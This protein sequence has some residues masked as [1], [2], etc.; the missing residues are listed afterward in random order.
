VTPTRASRPLA[1]QKSQETPTR[2]AAAPAARRVLAQAAW[3]TRVTLRNGEQLLLTLVLP[4]LALVAMSRTSLIGLDVPAEHLRVD[5]IAP[6]VLAMAVMSSAFTGQAIATAFDRRYGVLR[7]LGTTPLGRSGLLLGRVLAVLAVEIVQFAV[8]GGVAAWLG[9]RPSLGSLLLAVPLLVLGTA[10]FA[11]LGLLMAGTMRA[12]AVLAGANLVW[13]L[14]LL[15]GGVLLPTAKLPGAL[16]DV[17]ALLPSGALA[18][19]LRS[20]FLDGALPPSS[21]PVLAGWTAV[22]VAA[23][24]RWFKWQ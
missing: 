22:A 8:L 13:V 19:G 9:W 6:G 20:V 15:G 24:I 1:V 11:A 21:L 17:A 10:A 14:L 3:E 18:D 23:C 16:G 4:V 5:V 7:L 2:H 12:E